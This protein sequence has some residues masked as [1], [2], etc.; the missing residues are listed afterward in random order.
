MVNFFKWFTNRLFRLLAIALSPLSVCVEVIISYKFCGSNIWSTIFSAVQYG[1]LFFPIYKTFRSS[2][3]FIRGMAQW[4]KP[5]I[6]APGKTSNFDSTFIAQLVLTYSEQNKITNWQSSV[7]LPWVSF[8]NFI[9]W[10][11][12]ATLK[13]VQEICGHFYIQIDMG[14]PCLAFFLLN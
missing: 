13:K 9:L 10:F 4:Y 1:A 2:F 6:L 14:N 12:C 3:L 11:Q 7:F 5:S 8:F